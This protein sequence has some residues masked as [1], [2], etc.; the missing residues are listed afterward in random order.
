M[1][2]KDENSV[3]HTSAFEEL[4]IDKVGKIDHASPQSQPT[5]VHQLTNNLFSA[6]EVEGGVV[7]LAGCVFEDRPLIYLRPLLLESDAPSSHLNSAVCIDRYGHAVDDETRRLHSL[8]ACVTLKHPPYPWRDQDIADCLSQIWKV[9]CAEHEFGPLAELHITFAWCKEVSGKLSVNIGEQSETISFSDW[10]ARI[11]QPGYQPP[12]FVCPHTGQSS[13]QVA[14][15]DDGK[16]TVRSA[17]E[18]CE[19]SGH[20][21]IESDL[22]RCSV[23]GTRA[24]PQFMATCESSGEPVLGSAIGRCSRCNQNVSPTLLKRGACDACHALRRTSHDNSELTRLFEQHAGLRD[25]RG[26]QLATSHSNFLF[27]AANWTKK[28]LFVV[29]K[30][31][32]EIRY[33]GIAP[34]WSNRYRAIN[35]L[36]RKALLD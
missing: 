23:T 35:E 32:H 31:S 21:A 34:R 26:W 33:V 18:C 12:P 8:E 2:V 1:N 9:A 22:V 6:Y 14:A 16:I 11:V 17:I 10:G 4:A 25:L 27:R 5:Q 28:Y 13:H 36:E 7:Q 30:L 24:L 29:D 15:T 3:P 20:R 19:V